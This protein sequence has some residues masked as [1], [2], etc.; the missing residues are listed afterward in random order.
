MGNRKSRLRTEKLEK[1]L[2][3]GRKNTQKLLPNR[4]KK[5]QKLLPNRQKKTKKLLPTTS[6]TRPGTTTGTHTDDPNAGN[7]PNHHPQ[8]AEA[9]K[10]MSG[11]AASSTAGSL[12]PTRRWRS[13]S[14]PAST[15]C[16][17]N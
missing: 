10:T 3:T 16:S 1:K 11:T 9:S 12:G 6:I 2:P 5:M 13:T 8:H 7:D 14:I 4:R 15:R 17:R